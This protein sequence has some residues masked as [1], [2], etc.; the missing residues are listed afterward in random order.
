MPQR[1]VGNLC[2]VFA[3]LTGFVVYPQKN[4]LDKRG[5]LYGRISRVI[6]EMIKIIVCKQI[7]SND[8]KKF[9]RITINHQFSEYVA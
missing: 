5:T 3:L 9:T 4:R 7:I 8:L 1:L 6:Q 2:A